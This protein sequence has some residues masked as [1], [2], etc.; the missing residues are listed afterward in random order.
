V[1]SRTVPAVVLFPLLAAGG[2]ALGYGARWAEG[3]TSGHG[4]SGC[5]AVSPDSLS[6]TAI[7]FAVAVAVTFAAHAVTG[8]AL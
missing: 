5:A 3:C 4:L 1:L 7:F 8:G 6:A 2:L